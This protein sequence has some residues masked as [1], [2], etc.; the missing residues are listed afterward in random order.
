M[1]VL[2]ILK[3]NDPADGRET[4]RRSRLPL[5]VFLV[6]HGL[7]LATSLAGLILAIG[8]ALS[9]TGFVVVANLFTGP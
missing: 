4:V 7:W 2:S 3:R 8:D 5:V 9:E 1:P 6:T